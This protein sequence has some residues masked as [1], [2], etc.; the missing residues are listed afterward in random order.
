MKSERAHFFQY[1]HFVTQLF[2]FRAIQEWRNAIGKKFVTG[3]QLKTNSCRTC[4]VH[5]AKRVNAM[6][7]THTCNCNVTAWHRAPE[8]PLVPQTVTES[9]SW[10]P[11]VLKCHCASMLSAVQ[12]LKTLKLQK[13]EISKT[14]KISNCYYCYNSND[15][16]NNNSSRGVMIIMIKLSLGT[17]SSAL[18]CIS[19]A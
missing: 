3:S 15:N 6:M 16:N 12:Q 5:L 8:A 2:Y 18:I 14:S 17:S 1:V 10:S 19:G 9:D 7:I 13:S 4:T 11:W